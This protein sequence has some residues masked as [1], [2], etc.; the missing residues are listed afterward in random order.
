[1]TIFGT[2]VLYSLRFQFFF[3]NFV[4]IFGDQVHEEAAK[5]SFGR[6][7]FAPDPDPSRPAAH[8]PI[9][10]DPNSH[11]SSTSSFDLYLQQQFAASVPE[12]AKG[13]QNKI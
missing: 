1:M 3:T 6:P 10:K 2:A 7:F 12:P 8:V 5:V 11:P 9:T 4:I 13:I